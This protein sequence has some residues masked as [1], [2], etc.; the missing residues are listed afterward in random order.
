MTSDDDALISLADVA[1]GF[2]RAN[3]K[4]MRL[5]TVHRW[6]KKGARGRKLRVQRVGGRYYTTRRW[7][8]EFGVIHNPPD[9]E[10]D[11]KERR[12]RLGL[13]DSREAARAQKNLTRR[14]I[15]RENAERALSGMQEKARRSARGLR[16]L[17]PGGPLRHEARDCN[18]SG[19][20]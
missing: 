17:L 20:D 3:G 10:T 18:G 6:W 11:A 4:S 19:T 8:E 1:R 5:E 13:G 2:R 15:T 16:P 7:L 9:G 12:S 14:G